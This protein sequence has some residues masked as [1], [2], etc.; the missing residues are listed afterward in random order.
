MEN[1][2][3]RLG[4]IAIAIGVVA[5][6]VALTGRMSSFGAN[7]YNAYQ[8]GPGQQ[9]TQPFQNNPNVAPQA[10]VAPQGRMGPQGKVGPNM[11]GEGHGFRG[12]PGQMRG[13]HGW[14]GFFLW[15]FHILGG[16]VRLL[17]WGLLIFLGIKLF[18]RR[19]WGGPRGGWRGPWGRGPEGPRDE[20]H[21]DDNNQ[22]P[23]Y[24]GETQSF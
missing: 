6:L 10:P 4:W 12:G 22:N 8:Y 7:R 24:T 1:N 19:G 23:P 18:Q 9:F 14:F 13:G 21:D 17:F 16:L 15:P 20:K 3:R 5:L 11:R 2:G